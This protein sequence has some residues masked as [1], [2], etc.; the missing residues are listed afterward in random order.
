VSKKRLQKLIFFH[1]LFTYPPLVAGAGII[2]G[3]KKMPGLAGAV[4]ALMSKK[5]IEPG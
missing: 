2:P 5:F 4:T 1:P 3:A